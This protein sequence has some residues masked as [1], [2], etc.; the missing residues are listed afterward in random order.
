MKY[1]ITSIHTCILLRYNDIDYN[2][3][4]TYLNQRSLSMITVS[5]SILS[6]TLFLKSD[7]IISIHNFQLI[8]VQL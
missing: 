6:G 3:N 1:F 7:C 5:S 8:A 2:I 4:I